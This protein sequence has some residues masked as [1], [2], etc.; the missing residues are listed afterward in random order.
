M[1]FTTSTRPYRR[2][3]MTRRVCPLH[4]TLPGRSRSWYRCGCPIRQH[5]R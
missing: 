3:R 1:T 4:K 5:A 2:A